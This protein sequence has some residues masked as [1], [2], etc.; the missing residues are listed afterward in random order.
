MGSG[1]AAARYCGGDP[2]AERGVEHRAGRGVEDAARLIKVRLQVGE[3]VQRGKMRRQ[4]AEPLPH[5]WIVSLGG[6]P[7][8]SARTRTCAS[9][10][11]CASGGRMARRKG[12]AKIGV[13]VERVPL[14]SPSLDTAA[15]RVDCQPSTRAGVRRSGCRNVMSACN[16]APRSTSFVQSLDWFGPFYPAQGALDAIGVPGPDLPKRGIL[17][18]WFVCRR[19]FEPLVGD[20]GR[21][22]RFHV[23][24][25]ATY[26]MTQA[27]VSQGL[28]RGV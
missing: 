25:C 24:G 14:E 2:L 17:D 11:W 18:A 27:Q 16:S 23:D 3:P 15:I 8:A 19:G 6:F 5:S 20:R 22:E 21:R 28:T 13:R 26:V 7:F 10:G 9:P 12:A 4:G 1:G